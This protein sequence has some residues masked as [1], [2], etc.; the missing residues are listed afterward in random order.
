MLLQILIHTP[1]W[2]FAVFALL[3]WL[4]GRQMRANEAP[5][6]RVLLLPLVM[7]ALA[8]T[9]VTSV[10]GHA[11]AP[12]ALTMVLALWLLAALGSA[13]LVRRLPLAATVRYDAAAR[14]FHLPGS[15]LPLLLMMGIFATKYAVGVSLALHPLLARQAGFA[16]SITAV[17][18]VF[19]GIFLGR[20]LRLWRLALQAHRTMPARSRVECRAA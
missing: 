16:L 3:L 5:L 14:R 2:V 4:G 13:A 9:G 20:A 15:A 8:L 10:F 11:Q 7:V 18:G 1:V 12:A 17:Y 19:S 6:A